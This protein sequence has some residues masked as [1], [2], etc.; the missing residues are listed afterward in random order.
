[1]T[2]PL[3]CEL[4]AEA[5]AL[6]LGDL[7]KDH[8]TGIGNRRYFETKLEETLKNALEAGPEATLLLLDLDRFKAVNDS[9]GHAAGDSLL[10]LVAGRMSNLL[11]PDDT[12]A[13]LGGD[14]F[15]IISGSLEASKDLAG[16]LVDVVQRPYLVEG[17]AVNVGLSIG[18]AVTPFDGVSRSELMKRADLALYE[19]KEQGRNR[20]VRFEAR[21]EVLAQERRTLEVEL[22]KALLLKQFELHFRPQV[23][24]KTREL[25]VLETALFWRHPK[26]GL[27]H[28][29]VFLPMAESLG[30]MAAIGDWA[31]NTACREAARWPASVTVAISVSSSQFEAT[32]L[33]EVVRRALERNQISGERLE[34]EITETTLLRDGDCVHEA[35]SKLRALGVKVT[36]DGFG[37]GIASLSQMVGFPLDKIKIDGALIEESSAGRN[38]RAIVRAIAALGAGLGIPTLAAGVRTPEH[39]SRI[40]LD[41]C[42]LVQGYL[43]GKAVPANDLHS[44]V[45]KLLRSDVIEGQNQ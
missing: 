38:E 39:L 9:L 10:C 24:V 29:D 33:V 15:G 41:G 12:L 25:Q 18:L 30:I 43:I 26:R 23:D 21:M 35:L 3:V 13:R 45:E 31:F 20:Y 37:S 1:M 2:Q 19:A 4:S 7:L 17:S 8:L 16:R 44:S 22:R 40:Q 14:E 34:L 42:S 27:L 11:G 36:I 28:A 5:E 6:A 32:P